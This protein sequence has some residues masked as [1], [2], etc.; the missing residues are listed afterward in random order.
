MWL[1]RLP[2]PDGCCGLLRLHQLNV[3]LN[4]SLLVSI[5]A[6][7][8][9]SQNL[10]NKCSGMANCLVASQGQWR[11]ME[12]VCLVN[13]RFTL[14]RI[15]IAS[16]WKR[17]KFKEGK[18]KRDFSVV[19]RILLLADESQHCGDDA[20]FLQVQSLKHTFLR[21]QLQFLFYLGQTFTFMICE[22]TSCT[23]ARTPRCCITGWTL[24]SRTSHEAWPSVE[25]Y[26]CSSWTFA[27]VL[28]SYAALLNWCLSFWVS[29]RKKIP[30]GLCIGSSFRRFIGF[31]RI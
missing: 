1:T 30:Y 13:T 3:G 12:A 22:R 18:N 21:D 29:L 11:T 26:I 5:P 31:S 19:N 7:H 27:P 14:G 15:Q 25:A 16:L 10:N 28:Y 2:K 23:H 8:C 9:Q 17:K 4:E 6:L 20:L 24:A